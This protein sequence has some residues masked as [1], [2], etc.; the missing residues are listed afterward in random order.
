M[1]SD[2]KKSEIRHSVVAN[3][4]EKVSKDDYGK[5][6]KSLNLLKVR[7][8]NGDNLV[9]FEFPVTA[10]IGPNG[11]GKSTI[12]G[13]AACAYRSDY[14][15]GIFFPK[16]RIGDDGMSE[17]SIEYKLIDKSHNPKGAIKKTSQFKRA[18]WVREGLLPREVSYFGIVRTVPAS[19]RSNLK[20]LTKPSFLTNNLNLESLKNTVAT[21]VEKI[22]GKPVSSF[23][24]VDLSR[25][26]DEKFYIGGDETDQYSEFHFGAGESSVIRIV[27]GIELLSDNSLVLIEEIENGLHPVA[28]KRM[29]EYL[30]S[31]AERKKI[32]TIFTTHSDYAL[33]L[34]PSQAIWASI[35]GNLNQGKL[36]VSSLRAISG[37]LDQKLAIFVEDQFAQEWVESI[38]RE[39]LGERIG[40]IG[41]Y[42]LSGDGNAVKTHIS[43]KNNP[44]I[45]FKSICIIDGDSAQNDDPNLD[46][47]RLPGDIPELTVLGG[48]IAN[49]DTNLALLTISCQRPPE[50]QER[51]QKAIKSV[52]STYRDSHL[53]FNKI[54]IEIGFVPEPII[55]GAFISTWIRENKVLVEAVVEPILKILCLS[56]ET[57]S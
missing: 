19:E 8:F 20:K 34:L 49:I 48:V 26:K 41:V 9:N 44:A 30:I 39:T 37:R 25:S 50:D 27:T 16:S 42:A 7:R 14:K 2:L 52:L 4:L 46:I 54:G 24:S 56:N 18:R 22:L 10:L 51:V 43:H 38:L 31:V 11:G 32:Q 55:K 13:A 17:W 36:S 21:E 5:Y 45:L 29:V 33:E 12:L 28:V 3:L 57:N 47:Y 15:P 40:E 35:D 6:L 53:I 1:I 23:K